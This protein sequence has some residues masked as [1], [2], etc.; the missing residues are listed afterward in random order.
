MEVFRNRMKDNP[1]LK[2]VDLRNASDRVRSE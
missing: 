1:L 2:E